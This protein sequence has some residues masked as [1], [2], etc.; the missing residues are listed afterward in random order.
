M[1]N[2]FD[3]E[4]DLDSKEKEKVR[5]SLIPHHGVISCVTLMIDLL[6]QQFDYCCHNVH[7]CIIISWTFSGSGY[8]NSTKVISLHYQE[9]MEE[10]T[11]FNE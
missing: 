4:V 6:Y 1:S 7:V 9:F 11:N 5:T 3:A 2:V 8:V 10:Y